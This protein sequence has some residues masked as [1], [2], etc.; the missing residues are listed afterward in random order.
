MWMCPLMAVWAR[1][2]GWWMTASVG[3][4]AVLIAVLR[5]P[6]HLHAA[7]TQAYGSATP[8]FATCPFISSAIKFAAC[9]STIRLICIYKRDNESAPTKGKN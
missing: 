5:L 6:R 3:A 7:R 1:Q 8:P 2:E 9:S 4:D